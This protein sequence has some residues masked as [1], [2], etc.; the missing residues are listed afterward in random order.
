MNP[1][2]IKTTG[3]ARRTRKTLQ[4][5]GQIY[6]ENWF[7]GTENRRHKDGDIA[8]TCRIPIEV[9]VKSFGWKR[10]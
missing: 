6:Q 10:P 8:G 2:K 9:L 5:T 7:D 4:E 1:D 3:Q